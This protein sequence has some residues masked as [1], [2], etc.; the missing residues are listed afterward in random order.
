MKFV[1][2]T[3]VYVWKLVDDQRKAALRFCGGSS[4][5]AMKLMGATSHYTLCGSKQ[6]FSGDEQLHRNVRHSISHLLLS[7]QKPS[8]WLGDIKGG[9]VDEGLAHWF[10]EKAY[11]VCDT[12][13]YQEQNTKVDFKSGKYRFAMRKMIVEG[14]VP[15]VAEVFQ[16]NVDTLTLPMNCAAF[17]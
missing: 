5:R 8:R 3:R 2:K 4:D 17:T 7:H 13:C 9:W 11:G 10:E 14:N 1:E 12:Y 16:Q 15:P 6:F